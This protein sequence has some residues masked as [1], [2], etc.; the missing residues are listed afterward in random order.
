MYIQKVTIVP[1]FWNF[2][3]L[4]SIYNSNW[5][6]LMISQA[7]KPHLIQFCTASVCLLLSVRCWMGVQGA[8]VGGWP[9]DPQPSHVRCQ[10]LTHSSPKTNTQDIKVLPGLLWRETMVWGTQVVMV[11]VM[12]LPQLVE[13][14]RTWRSVV[15]D[16]HDRWV[17]TMLA[18][19]VDTI[20]MITISEIWK[21]YSLREDPHKD[22]RCSNGIWPNGVSPPPPP[23]Y[24]KP[25]LYKNKI[26][27]IKK[28][29][30]LIF[31]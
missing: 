1:V 20:G 15:D 28:N 7:M 14:G 9:R 3:L 29:F 2:S 21:H 8:D 26:S 19:L 24:A 6:N 30:S 12:V 31:Y 18:S 16:R 13:P 5:H 4:T 10:S 23:H 17:I 11:M 27:I 22:F 25:L